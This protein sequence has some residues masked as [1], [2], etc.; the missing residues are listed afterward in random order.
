MHR[1]VLD[2]SHVTFLDSS[3]VSALCLAKAKLA[4]DGTVL[5]LGELSTPVNAVLR[6]CGLESEFVRDE[7]ASCFRTTV[8][9]H[10]HGWRG[11]VA[12][13]CMTAAGAG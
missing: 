5:V 7:S 4:V 11:R 8:P 9:P 12:P 13:W 2:L 1:V 10:P 3:G 6:M